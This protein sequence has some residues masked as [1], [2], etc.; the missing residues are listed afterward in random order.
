MKEYRCRDKAVR[1]Q[2]GG[3]AGL[4]RAVSVEWM[5]R[6]VGRVGIGGLWER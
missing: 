2:G 4:V 6:G 3:R 5:E 1:C